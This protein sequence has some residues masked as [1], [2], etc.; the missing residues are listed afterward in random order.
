[1]G[2]RDEGLGEAMQIAGA[3]DDARNGKAAALAKV[4]IAARQTADIIR[5]GAETITDPHD[6]AAMIN[7]AKAW[8]YF[9]QAVAYEQPQHLVDRPDPSSP[10]WLSNSS[11]AAT[12]LG[13]SGLSDLLGDSNVSS[14]SG[15]DFGGGG[16]SGSW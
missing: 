9:S 5:A 6:L 11:G 2:F 8:D 13:F 4:S 12:S 7:M 16:S 1:M 3:R 10:A 14:G 15:G